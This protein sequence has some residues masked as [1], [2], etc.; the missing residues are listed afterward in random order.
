M[1][2]VLLGVGS[3]GCATGR[4]QVGP[5]AIDCDPRYI[6]GDHDLDRGWAGCR[7]TE[8]FLS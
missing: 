8:A 3:G 5:K 2:L 6:D 7:G 4:L 1:S